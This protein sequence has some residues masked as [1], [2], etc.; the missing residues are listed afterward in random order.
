MRV[1][2]RLAPQ[3][4]SAEAELAAFIAGLGEEGAVVSFVGIARP[5]SL[6][7]SPL[8]RLFLD[9]HPRLTERSL[10][11]PIIGSTSTPLTAPARHRYRRLPNTAPT[12]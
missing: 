5:R 10:N 8:A 7:G 3:P 9:H 1:D 2:A 11:A 12:N 6:D 4:L